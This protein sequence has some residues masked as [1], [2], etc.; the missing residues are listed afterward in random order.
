M[1]VYLPSPTRQHPR[2]GHQLGLLEDEFKGF[3]MISKDDPEV[4]VPLTR[5]IVCGAIPHHLLR[6][7]ASAKPSLSG[8]DD[9]LSPVGHL[10]LAED[11]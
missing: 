5:K 4:S 11:M 6:Q 3:N 9:R 2:S 8:A 1:V 10:E 7:G